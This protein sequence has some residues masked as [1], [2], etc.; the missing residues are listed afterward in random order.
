MNDR[1]EVQLPPSWDG[2]VIVDIGGDVGALILRTPPMMV[3]DEIGLDA[4]DPTVAHVH[5]AVRER[6][7][8]DGSAYAAVYPSLRAGDYFI[9]G[10]HLR[11]TVVGGQV[12]DVAYDGAA[13][14]L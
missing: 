9:E 13:M 2:S 6:R 8:D 7:L 10:T 14:G 1:E 11:V 4:L 5:S 3:D 12:V